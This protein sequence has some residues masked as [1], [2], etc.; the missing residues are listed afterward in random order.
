MFDLGKFIMASGKE[1]NFKIEC[2]SLSLKDWESLAWLIASKYKFR[3]AIGVP[4]GGLTLAYYLNNYA[5]K[6]DTTLPLL[7]VDDVLTT[8]GS[9]E[10]LKSGLDKEEFPNIMG[11]VVFARGKCPE[12]IKPIFSTEWLS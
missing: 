10:K 9:I 11:V 12:W 1:G 6:N 2:D 5:S 7:I 3:L 4:R 8:G